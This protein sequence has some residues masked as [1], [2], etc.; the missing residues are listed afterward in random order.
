[1]IKQVVI[2]GAGPAGLTAACEILRE[3]N[4]H[5]II[6][7][8]TD[9]IGGISRTVNYK[10]NRMD[11]GGHRFFSKDD[12]IIQF[13]LSVMNNDGDREMMERD[14][15][16]RIYFLRKFFSYPISL[17]TETF[18]NLGIA[19][20]VKSGI[21]YLIAQLFPKGERTLEDFYI[22][23]FGKTL[24]SL[25][26][27]DYTTKVWGKHP[28]ELSADWGRQRVKGVSL[29]VI[30]R[31][32]IQK[33]ILKR[34]P[35][36][37]ETSLIE[38]FLYPKFGPGQ[39]W[40]SVAEDI[41]KNGGELRKEQNVCS[42]YIKENKVYSV[43]VIASDGSRTNIKCDYLFSS[44]P[45][46]ELIPSLEGI[47]VPDEVRKIASK[48][49]Y[50]DFITVGLLV[51]KLEI[52]DKNG[53]DIVPDTWIYIQERD[54]KVGRL[55]IFNNWSPFLVKDPSTVWVGL[56]YFCNENDELWNMSETEFIQMA[57]DEMVKIDIIKRDAVLDAH[58]VK[59]KKAYPAYFG[60]YND[61]DKVRRFLDTIDNL[62]CIGRNGQHRYNNMDHSMLTAMEAVD[63]VKKNVRSKENVWSVN[64]EQEYHEKIRK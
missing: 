9:E 24:Y 29:F 4:I 38:K 6:F 27:E 12:R 23:R 1:M 56:E 5:P 57:V 55:Q 36:N 15:I 25:F 46:K 33:K 13:W 63:N 42:I 39:L 8:K 3:T 41:V 62:Y 49:P 18:K 31:D 30:I 45:V 37:V 11:I 58:Q 43:D 20:T 50:R 32:Y 54:V 48:L 22:N 64:T 61:F 47:D 26:F 17:T 28:S 52:H 44:M 10:G 21:A 35:E 40:E 51:N 59:V 19:N 53:K 60:S 34:E 2:V 7:E 16:S 14:R